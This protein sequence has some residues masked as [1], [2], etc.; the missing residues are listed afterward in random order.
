M[1]LKNAAFAILAAVLFQQASAGSL[2]MNKGRS[3]QENCL[4][5]DTICFEG[6]TCN[7][8]C[9]SYH[10]C[11]VSK[12]Y[13]CNVMD[14]GRA[15]DLLD[16]LGLP[17]I[18]GLPDIDIQ[19]LDLETLLGVLRQMDFQDILDLLNQIDLQS[20]LDRLGLTDLQDLLDRVGQIGEGRALE[21]ACFPDGTQCDNIES[22]G[23]DSCSNCCNAASFWPDERFYW[24]CG[25]MPCWGTNTR[26]LAGTTCN[27]CCNGSRWV[28]E[29]FGDH[30]N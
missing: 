1:Y 30:C 29:W 13:R 11:T 6:T 19:N 27:S 9:N 26:C 17:D 7:N 2:R 4:E 25:Q 14:E 10:W 22:V 16:D 8:C 28:W 12:S 20:L 23:L 3:L 5:A 24:A 18:P 15:L 21:G